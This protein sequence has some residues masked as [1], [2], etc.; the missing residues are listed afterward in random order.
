[1]SK[2]NISAETISVTEK[3]KKFYEKY[4]FPGNRPLDRDGIIFLR[5]FNKSVERFQKKKT[6]LYILDAGCGTGNTIISLA[7]YFKKIK[8]IGIDN[9]KASLLKAAKSVQNKNLTNIVLRKGNLINPLP[10][11][12]RF[13][14]IYCLGV[15]HHTADMTLVLKNLYNSLQDD[16]ELYLWIYAKHGRY[17]HTLNVKLLNMLLQV[18]SDALDEVIYTKEFLTGVK[19]NI[20]LKELLGKNIDGIILSDT[21]LDP[22]WIADQ[23]LNPN[24]ILL[25]MEELLNLV[26]SC[27]LK[28]QQVLGISSEVEN[29]FES[30]SLSNSFRKLSY[31]NQLIAIDLLLKP[32]RHFIILKKK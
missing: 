7:E 16:G 8:F 5:R 6:K 4:Q 20:V 19:N 24:E 30:E 29:Y 3:S 21:F 2:L 32:E 10:Y 13:D 26:K 18:K 27:G 15:L 25:D 31:E 11:K 23:F 22:V 12:K 9:S 1:M 17:Y 28:I 14:I